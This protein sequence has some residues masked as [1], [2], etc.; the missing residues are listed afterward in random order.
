MVSTKITIGTTA[1]VVAAGLAASALHLDI[2]RY[3]ITTT[4]EF[5]LVRV[6]TLVMLV[7]LLFT[8]PPRS[9]YMRVLLGAAGAAFHVWSINALLNT[10]G[11]SLDG[12]IFMAVAIVLEVEALEPQTAPRHESLR[13]QAT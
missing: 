10:V 4:P 11:A 3:F 6:G 9:L 8:K 2:I 5:N 1:L 12:L 7:S 13:R